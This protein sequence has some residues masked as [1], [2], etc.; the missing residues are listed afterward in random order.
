ME[1]YRWNSNTLPRIDP[2]HTYTAT[3]S[4]WQIFGKFWILSLKRFHSS[5]LDKK[6]YMRTVLIIMKMQI[7]LTIMKFEII[8][9]LARKPQ[10]RMRPK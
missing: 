1:T 4:K 5:I 2:I 6:K 8:M 3:D 7:N 10:T 9:L